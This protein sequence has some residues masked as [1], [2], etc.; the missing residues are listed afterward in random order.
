MTVP[1]TIAAS[2]R[3]PSGAAAG[4]VVPVATGTV[5]RAAVVRR[6][7]VDRRGGV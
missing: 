4:A 1:S 5:R 3:R 7:G 2:V 6:V